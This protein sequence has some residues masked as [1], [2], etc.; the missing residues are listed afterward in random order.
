MI[1]AVLWLFLAILSLRV[2]YRLFRKPVYPRVATYSERD[3]M[4]HVVIDMLYILLV[5]LALL[6]HAERCQ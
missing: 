6:E 4:W 3:D 5:V 1:G 2:L